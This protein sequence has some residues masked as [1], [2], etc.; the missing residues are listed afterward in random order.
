MLHLCCVHEIV[1]LAA[2]Q[3]ASEL[4]RYGGCQVKRTVQI[5]L[6]TPSQ[7]VIKC[8]MILPIVSPVPTATMWTALTKNYGVEDEPTR[9]C[10]PCVGDNGTSDVVSELDQVK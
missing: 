1:C 9:K 2:V 8:V 3:K 6:T 4:L 7:S 10:L 5:Q